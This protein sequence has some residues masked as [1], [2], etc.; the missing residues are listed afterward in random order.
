VKSFSVN[1]HQKAKG[2]FTM[3]EHTHYQ[4]AGRVVSAFVG[5][6]LFGAI[7]TLLVAPQSGRDTQEQIRQNFRRKSQELR[8]LQQKTIESYYGM[9]NGTRQYMEEMQSIVKEAL[10][11]GREEIQKKREELAREARKFNGNRRGVGAE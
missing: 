5:G 4:P 6:V 10:Q 8:D 3:R 1:H 2:Y 9:I 11:A 7:T